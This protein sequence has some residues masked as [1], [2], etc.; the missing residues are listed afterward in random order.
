MRDTRRRSAAWGL[1]AILPFLATAVS[2]AGEP[3]IETVTTFYLVRHAE[4]AGGGGDVELLEEGRRRAVELRELLRDVPWTA[5]YSTDWKRT[6]QTA[7]PIVEASGL[8]PLSYPPE[9]S[10]SVRDWAD[11]LIERHR[12]GNV[13]VVGHS[14]P[15]TS[16]Y[17]LASIVQE[18]ARGPVAEIPETDYRNLFVVTIRESGTDD[19][20]R[21]R[22]TLE[23]R[24][25]D[26]R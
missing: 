18:L 17:S 8:E 14:G 7:A 19:G 25:F 3:E 16:A 1:L 12:G 10:T 2:G 5:I 20:Q 15:P 9:D 21:P 24:T 23:H 11:G 13:L 22:R 6:R 26:P 4:K